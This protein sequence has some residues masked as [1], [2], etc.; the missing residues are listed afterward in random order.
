MAGESYVFHSQH[1]REA[2]E[3]RQCP[4]EKFITMRSSKNVKSASGNL[5]SH[6]STF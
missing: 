2:P 4:L 5:I 1:D 3:Y 6:F